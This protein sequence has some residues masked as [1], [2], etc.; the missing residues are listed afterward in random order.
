[1]R[2]KRRPADKT[3]AA[4]PCDPGRCPFG[5]GNPD[6]TEALE[7]RP[8][9]VMIGCPAERLIR[10]PRPTELRPRPVPIQVRA[11]AKVRGRARPPSV[12]VIRHFDPITVW[13]ERVIKKVKR[14]FCFRGICVASRRVRRRATF[15]RCRFSFPGSRG[16]RSV[17]ARQF[18]APLFGLAAREIAFRISRRGFPSSASK[19]PFSPGAQRPGSGSRARFLFIR[20]IRLRPILF[21]GVSRRRGARWQRV[22]RD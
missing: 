7:P 9:A 21:A 3:I 14:L 1:M 5:T 15:F 8:P 16:E 18:R 11:P 6:P 13:R 4:A 10:D 2:R 22:A 12:S 17:F 20:S 19:G